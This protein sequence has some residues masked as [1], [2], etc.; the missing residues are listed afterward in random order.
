VTEPSNAPPLSGG[1]PFSLPAEWWPFQA[2]ASNERRIPVATPSVRPGPRPHLYHD[3][4]RPE[5]AR[6]MRA[7]GLEVTYVRAE[8]DWM[9]HETPGGFRRRVLDMLGGYGANLFGHHHPELVATLRQVLDDKAPIQAQASCRAWAG[10]VAA[11]LSER[12]GRTTGRNY[13]VTLANT[14]AEAIEAALK[15]AEL[16]R[17][18]DAEDSA[19]RFRRRIA[20]LLQDALPNQAPFLREAARELDLRAGATAADALDAVAEANARAY[21]VSPVY[22]ALERAFHGKT[23]GA[24][25][26]THNPDYRR[27]FERIGVRCEFLPSGD[28]GAWERAISRATVKTWE[29]ESQGGQLMLVERPWVNVSAILVEPIQGEGGIHVLSHADA[30]MLRA[31][32]DQHDIPVIVD[33]IQAGLGRTGDF[34]AASACGLRGDYYVFAKSLGGGLVKIG[35]LA[36]ERE[37]YREA[38]GVIH[39]STFAEDDLSC[40][41]AL[42]ALELI[43]EKDVPG[44]CRQAGDHLLESLRAVVAKHPT[45]LKEARGRGL[46]VGLEFHH[47]GANPSNVIRML[48]DQGYL[49]Y[50]IAGYML[51]EEGFR[52]APTLSAATTIRLEPSAFIEGVQLERFAEAI[53]RLCTIIER[54][55]AYR[56]T[57][58]LV[59]LSD[60][61]D[62]S[63]PEDFRVAATGLRREAPRCEKRVGFIGHFIHARDAVAWDPSLARLPAG[64]V[65]HYQLAAHRVLGPTIYDQAHVTSLIGETVHLSF[66]GI[67]LTSKSIEAAMQA[68]DTGWII[69][70][71]QQA[72]YKA[73]EAGCQVVGLGG[74]TS[75]VTDNGRRLV[76]P[77]GVAITT[78]NSLTVGMGIAA[79]RRGALELGIPIATSS[80]GVVGA[81]GNIGAVHARILAAEVPRL[82][83]VGR[84]G[85]SRLAGVAAAIYADAFAAIESSNEL[86]G[87][88]LAIANTEVVA[89]LRATP[90]EART[91]LG[92]T[93]AEGLASELGSLVPVIITNDPAALRGCALIVACSNS[94]NPVI[95]PE[96]LA[97]GPV[98]I[99]DLSVP[100]DVDES[101]EQVRPDVL[102]IR[103][104]LV[105]IPGDA[106]FH[107]GGIPLPRGHAFACMSETLL[108][109]LMGVRDHFSQGPVIPAKVKQAMAW[110]DVNGFRLGSYKQ[111]RSF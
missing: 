40:R 8:G 65:K 57:R 99:C 3:A 48:S 107:I 96:H 70:L 6:L 55:N 52:V 9:E 10:E 104:G 29:V 72:V 79:L 98:V 35:A 103:G 45:V 84:Q 33:E 31:F 105:A 94:A 36:V 50:A 91:R 62:R 64:A 81:A 74:Y 66:I 7:L 68:R 102:V 39:T 78:G 93:L 110:A 21:A 76:A 89:K 1:A 67:N 51:H 16:A 95:L 4:A 41:V 20:G 88:A 44:L 5:L 109:G 27:P 47:Q 54:G 2:V 42:R 73:H 24:A 38:F 28:Q 101:I 83:L 15:H 37:R 18:E 63:I 11:A 46:M 30:A 58:Y 25:Q 97:S 69:D 13:I 19:R 17:Y 77:P 75:I 92:E 80:L 108:L 90:R 61:A 100:A 49:G 87:V 86:G 111:N 26:V 106:D 23:S 82:V 56:M 85:G 34:L 12:I 14:G 71:I 60:P 53:E 22:F 59:G 43:D 32:A